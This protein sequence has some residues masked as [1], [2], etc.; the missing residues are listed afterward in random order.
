MGVLRVLS[1]RSGCLAR[2]MLPGDAGGYPGPAGSRQ[3]GL[4][5]KSPFWPSRPL[6]S[7]S[8]RHSR[9]QY[10]RQDVLDEHLMADQ[11]PTK[12]WTRRERVSE[13]PPGP[14]EPAQA[15]G[16]RA[17]EKYRRR[18]KYMWSPVVAQTCLARRQDLAAL[19]N[20]SS[21][22]GQRS[23][24]VTCG[25]AQQPRITPFQ[26]PTDMISLECLQGESE[27]VGWDFEP[28]FRMIPFRSD[29]LNP[30]P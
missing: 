17:G 24:G 20:I 1:A 27:G 6:V 23:K 5:G 25:A 19:F 22:T 28:T 12:T 16:S 15:Q 11:A 7:R 8:G 30:F 29:V 9:H 3:G 21:P 13:G 14:S 18:S 26:P 10:G 4:S 2:G